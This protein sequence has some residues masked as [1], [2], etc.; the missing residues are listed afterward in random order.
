MNTNTNKQDGN[1][2]S[3]GELL[4]PNQDK[5]NMENG[6]QELKIEEN[7]DNQ[8]NGFTSKR[9]DGLAPATKIPDARR[10]D[11][12]YNGASMGT[13]NERSSE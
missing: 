1:A 9:R 2:N 6:E 7:D 8:M 12:N 3:F 11:A 13:L 4:Q 5:N 10:L